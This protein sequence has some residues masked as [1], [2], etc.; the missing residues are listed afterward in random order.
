[1]AAR[2]QGSINL[3]RDFDVEATKNRGG[4]I[5]KDTEE[6]VMTVKRDMVKGDN[7]VEEKHEMDSG[8]DDSADEMMDFLQGVAPKDNQANNALET[9]IL[10]D[11]D[12]SFEVNVGPISKMIEQRDRDGRVMKLEAD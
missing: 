4:H 7:E 5:E 6:L 8:N 2:K 12:D 1:M 10:I 3:F 9:G 11:P